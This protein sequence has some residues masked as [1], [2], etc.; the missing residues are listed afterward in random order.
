MRNPQIFISIPDELNEA[1]KR[2]AAQRGQSIS[3][4]VRDLLVRLDQKASE[5]G[6]SISTVIE[7]ILPVEGSSS[8]SG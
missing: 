6:V 5:Q 3:A 7:R 1:I 2:E 8:R 4:L